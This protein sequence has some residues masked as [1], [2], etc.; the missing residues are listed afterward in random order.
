M[1]NKKSLKPIKDFL[2]KYWQKWTIIIILGI[3]IYIVFV[4]YQYIYKPV[5]QPEELM[6]QRLE[7]K[8][9][10]YQEIMNF[11]YQ[12]G[13]NINIILNKNYPNPFK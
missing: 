3:I 9:G 6:P 1:K 7:I 5:Y 8:E 10:I 11:Y 12:Q 13:E 4:F 2:K